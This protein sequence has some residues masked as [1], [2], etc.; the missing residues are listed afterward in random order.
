M[1]YRDVS[2]GHVILKF[3]EGIRYKLAQELI[4][5]SNCL[6]S[7]LER[8]TATREQPCHLQSKKPTFAPQFILSLKDTLTRD[9]LLTLDLSRFGIL[10]LH[11]LDN[12]NTVLHENPLWL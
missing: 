8:T 9:R 3:T 1:V 6:L 2:Q 10:N 12:S 11:V 4:E 7:C 5:D